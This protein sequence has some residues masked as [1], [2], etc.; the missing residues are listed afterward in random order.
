[1]HTDTHR[2][3]LDLHTQVANDLRVLLSKYKNPKI[4]LRQISAKIQVS[5]RTITRLLNKENK[6]TYQTLYKIYRVIY[7]TSD[8]SRLFELLPPIVQDEIKRHNPLKQ[9]SSITY[10]KEIENEILYDRCF[11]E[12]YFLASC[13][14]TSRDLIQLRFGLH[15]IETVEKMIELGALKQTREGTYTIGD[16]QAN[17]DAQTLKRVGLSI[18]EKYAKV[19][20]TQTRGNN[21]IAF[22]AEGLSDEAY[23]QWLKIDQEAFYKKVEIANAEGAKGSKRAFT[24][25]V[26]DTMSLK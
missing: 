6:P 9:N 1:M 13:S 11:A 14:P 4:G 19:Q 17:L 21:L 24:F 2:D 10:K 8:D 25:A 7:S 22:Y 26:T 3:Q 18:S 5:E 20:N 23:E 12:I 16:V 15:G